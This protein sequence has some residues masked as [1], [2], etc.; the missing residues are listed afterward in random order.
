MKLFAA[1]ACSGLILLG[2]AARTTRAADLLI[3]DDGRPWAAIFVPARLLDDARANPEPATVWRSLKAEDNRCR[4]RE[5]VKDL[6]GVLGR[7][8]GA[9]V[10]VVAGAP[11]AGD[12]RIPILVGELAAGGSASRRRPTPMA[13]GSASWCP[14]RVSG[15][16]ALWSGSA[17]TVLP[18]W[19]SMRPVNH[20]AG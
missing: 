6:A 20:A 10:E 14:T 19:R 1:I 12:K 11:P 2:A 5:S 13:R 4:L 17:L 7:V 15:W 9:K 8:S 16:P 18:E 3:I